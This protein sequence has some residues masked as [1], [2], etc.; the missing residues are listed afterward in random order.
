MYESNY[1][2]PAMGGIMGL[3]NLDTAND[4]EEQI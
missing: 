4:V 2:P 3:Y 1:F